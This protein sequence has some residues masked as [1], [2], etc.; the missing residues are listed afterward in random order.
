MIWQT[1]KFY[2]TRGWREKAATVLKTQ[3]KTLQTQITVLVKCSGKPVFATLTLK[4]VML[5]HCS[6]CFSVKALLYCAVA[7]C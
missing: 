7:L 6:T 4:P 5:K 1:V 2:I 3:N